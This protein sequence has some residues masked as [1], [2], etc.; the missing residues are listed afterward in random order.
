MIRLTRV[1]AFLGAALLLLLAVIAVRAVTWK[2]PVWGEKASL[3]AA[4]PVDAARAAAHLGEAVRFR[5]VSNQDPAR[6]EW[7]EW[8]RL[9]AWLAV[10]YPGVHR[11]MRRETVAG[12][13]LIYV[14]P[15]SDPALKPVVLMAH[16]DVVPAQDERPIRC[17]HPAFEGVLDC[18]TVWGRGTLDDKGSLVALMESAETLIARGFAPRRTLYFVFGHDEEAGGTGATAAA[19]WLAARSVQ[20]LFV[21]DE[22]GLGLAQDPLNGRPVAF[23]GVTEKGYATLKVT[24]RGVGGH[25]SAPPRRTAA[26]V[27][28]RAVDRIASR[29]FP[30]KFD[31]VSARTIEGLAAGSSGMKRALVANAWLFGPVIADAVGQVP[32]GAATLHTTIAPT[33]LQGSP[34]EN[35]LP[36]TAT[37]LINYRLHPRDSLQSAMA[38]ARRAVGDLP[39][40]LEWLPG[41]AGAAPTASTTSAEWNVLAALARESVGAP[42]VPGLLTGATDGRRMTRLTPNVYRFLPV[43]VDRRELDGFHGSHEHLSAANVERML[44]FYTRLMLTTAG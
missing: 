31:G 15:G 21:L 32:S 29:P 5:T 17:G 40:E 42:P 34:K 33:V 36:Q 14:W 27:L 38:R 25:S 10:T 28:A 19:A 20:P 2:P 11:V 39:V 18:G 4:V 7:G 37:A 12:R 43:L 6:N 41:A 44:K 1:L 16:Q 22:G 8:D 26:H 23:I 24:A 3:A 13:T 35:V 9:H 30:L